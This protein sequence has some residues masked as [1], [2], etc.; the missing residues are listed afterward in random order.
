MNELFEYISFARSTHDIVLIIGFLSTIVLIS[1]RPIR[2]TNHNNSHIWAII[3]GILVI[4]RLG[5]LP[6]GWGTGCDRENYAFRLL[7]SNGSFA[8]QTDP[9]FSHISDIIYSLYP[10]IEAYFI[11]IAAIYIIIYLWACKRLVNYQQGWLFIVILLSLGFIQYGCNTIRAG[12]AFALLLLGITFNWKSIAQ[13]V[14]FALAAGIH[15]SVSIPVI[16]FLISGIYPKTKLFFT[17]WFLSI[18]ISFFAGNYFNELFLTFDV[19]SRTAYLTEANQNYNIGFR[20]DFIIY[21][22]LPI[23]VGYYYIFKREFQSALYSKLYNTYIL[24]NI[25]WILVIRAN[26]SDRFAYLS[27]FLIPIILAFPILK[28]PTIVDKPNTWLATIILGETVFSMIV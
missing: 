15:M 26:F 23:A 11:I 1:Y 8:D 6:I 14:C 25:F 5:C 20:F 18:P 27:W 3:I 10:N 13:I 21:S 12:L 9:L 22:M 4:Y 7:R 17:L 28:Q 19:D 2:Q 16:M 24:S